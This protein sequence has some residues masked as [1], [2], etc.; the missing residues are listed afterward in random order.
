MRLLD[1]A[2]LSFA[3]RDLI[4]DRLPGL[5]RLS[6]ALRAGQANGIAELT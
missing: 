5:P 3:A 2:S 4:D 1:M 6:A